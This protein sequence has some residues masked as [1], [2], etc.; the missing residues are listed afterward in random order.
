MMAHASRSPVG[1]LTG[2]NQ[3][4]S[5]RGRLQSQSYLSEADANSRIGNGSLRNGLRTATEKSGGY[6]GSGGWES[7]LLRT[8]VR[9]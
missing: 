8:P 2:Q 3:Y 4:L 5:G 1:F 9:R 7:M 6:H